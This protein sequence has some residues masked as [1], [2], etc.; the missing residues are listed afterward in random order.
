[1][2]TG[3]ENDFSKNYLNASMHDDN[4]L[5]EKL[6]M[7]ELGKLIAYRKKDVITTIRESGIP[8]IENASPSTVVKTIEKNMAGNA[9][10]SDNLAKLMAGKKYHNSIGETLE[11]KNKK[12]SANNDPG[13]I[14][15]NIGEGL[16]A[17][18]SIDQ[19]TGGSISSGLKSLFSK[20]N[21]DQPPPATPSNQ[22]INK[23]NT[24]NKPPKK[25]NTI[26]YIGI[27][28]VVIGAVITLL[29]LKKKKII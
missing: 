20:K 25:S 8:I 14:G 24:Y 22:V 13:K 1:M 9:N 4:I 12:H 16:A 21:K 18:H 29:I 27:G 19:M 3:K 6:L 5:A 7:D 15:Q 28:V 23:T 26:L 2:L 10:L 17:Y 11:I